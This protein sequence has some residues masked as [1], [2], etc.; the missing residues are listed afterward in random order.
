MKATPLNEEMYQY[1]VDL[2]AQDEIALLEPMKRRAD[3]AGV[4]EIMISPEQAR[5]VGFFLKAIG[6]KRVLDIGT[7]FGYSAAIM[8]KAVGQSGE[9]VTLE[10]SSKHAAVARENFRELGLK[11]ITLHEGAALDALKTMP[12]NSFD[13]A[14]ID[15]DKANYENYLMECLRLVRNG[16]VIAGDNTMAFG[17]ITDDIAEDNPDYKSVLAIRSFNKRFV[18]E[19]R[20]FSSF[21]TIG[22]G[23]LAGVVTK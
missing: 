19:P 18:A 14:M 8:S 11:N 17:Y 21:I 22:D 20:L 6:A 23:M 15:A 2:V 1:I 3:A 12:D 10:Y 13:F 4:P 7:L 9:V 16:G 5:F